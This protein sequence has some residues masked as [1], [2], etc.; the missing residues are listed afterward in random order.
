LFIAYSQEF[1]KVIVLCKDEKT[2]LAYANILFNKFSTGT[3]SNING[4]FHTPIYVDSITISYLGY[5]T[6]KLRLES[7]EQKIYLIKTITNT[8]EVIIKSY[9]EHKLAEIL[10]KALQNK[11]KIKKSTKSKSFIRLFSWLP[12]ENPIELSEGI[13]NI[14]QDNRGITK[15]E[16]KNGRYFF[17]K[18]SLQQHFSLNFISQLVPEI[19]YFGKQ[20]LLMGIVSPLNLNSTNEI[21]TWYKLSSEYIANNTIKIIYYSKANSNDRGEIVINTDLFTPVSLKFCKSNND[22]EIFES[23]N[24]Q[25]KINNSKVEFTIYFNTKQDIELL[26]GN[27]NYELCEDGFSNNIST[28]IEVILFDFNNPFSSIFNLPKGFN[29]YEKMNA[30]LFNDFYWNQMQYM[31]RTNKEINFERHMSYSVSQNLIID[32]N[33]NIEGLNNNIPKNLYR[34]NK[35]KDELISKPI[36][37]SLFHLDISLVANVDKRDTTFICDVYPV[38]NYANSYSFI[39]DLESERA[40][41]DSVIILSIAYAKKLNNILNPMLKEG[42]ISNTN[43]NQL[44]DDFQTSYNNKSEE[45]LNKLSIEETISVPS[46]KIP[47][48]SYDKLQFFLK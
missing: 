18:D 11:T 15:I 21:T 2:P 44:I 1:K 7:N 33:F 6:K 37:N 47:L 42:N 17:T 8:P 22:S 3:I 5:E 24:K 32:G 31:N 38:L 28:K 39:V 12:D 25:T 4:E 27:I 46:Q 9:S 29:D 26:T 13:Y 40:I 48:S 19:N 30:I 36:F 35:Y 23:T 16:L 20:N 14:Q 34:Y 41:I 45:F 10:I 43:A